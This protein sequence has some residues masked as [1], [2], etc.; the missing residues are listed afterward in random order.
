MNILK[1]KNLYYLGPEGSYAQS[2][3]HC[4]VDDLNICAENLIPLKPITKILQTID[5]NPDDMAVLPIENSI[6]GIVRETIDNLIKINNKS[7]NISAE[8]VIPIKHCLV[9]QSNNIS[10]ITNILSHPQALGQCSEYICKHFQ[11]VNIIET[12]STSEAAKIAKQKGNQYAAIASELTAGI[13]NLNILKKEINDE[14]DNKTRFI[15][16]SNKNNNDVN[17]NKTSIFFTVINEPGSL[18]NV[19]N[20]FHK[21]NINL[22]YIESR[23]S[24]KKMGEYNFYVDIDGNINDKNIN[25]AIN[26]TERITKKLIILGSYPKFKK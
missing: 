13:Y 5:E 16:L 26:L 17:D 4:F 19:L 23:P 21:Y 24:K 25:A 2:A 18:V 20:I 3:M 6:E 15:L 1:T 10:D 7:I 8:T 22:L 14:K 9:S 11:G 12:S